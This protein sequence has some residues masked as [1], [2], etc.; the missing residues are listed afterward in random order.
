MKYIYIG[1][2]AFNKLKKNI[3]GIVSMFFTDDVEY[4]YYKDHYIFNR[5]REHFNTEDYM[6]VIDTKHNKKQSWSEYVQAK[7]SCPESFRKKHP[8]I[9]ISKYSYDGDIILSEFGL[10]DIS[11]N[12]C[13]QIVNFLKD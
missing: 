5:I 8:P 13:K 7:Y 9:F 2:E 6:Y 12:V 4:L 3:D 11:K 1:V 10:D